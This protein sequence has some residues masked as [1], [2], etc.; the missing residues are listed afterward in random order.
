MKNEPGNTFT[1]SSWNMHVSCCQFLLF[2]PCGLLFEEQ[3]HGFIWNSSSV[4]SFESLWLRNEF[5]FCFMWLDLWITLKNVFL[6]QNG[7]KG[8]MKSASCVWQ[9]FFQMSDSISHVATKMA[10]ISMNSA[11]MLLIWTDSKEILLGLGPVYSISD[12]A[13]IR[14]LGW[15]TSYKECKRLL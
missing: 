5:Y 14:G 10:W 1:K 12:W 3:K 9:S 2:L 15:H 8:S 4:N 11:V 7:Q 13:V 6:N